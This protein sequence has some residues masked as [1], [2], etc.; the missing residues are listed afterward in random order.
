MLILIKSIFL[1]SIISKIDLAR[2]YLLSL[3]PSG[4]GPSLEKEIAAGSI[5]L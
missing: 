3:L 5:L 1:I 4:K 2:N